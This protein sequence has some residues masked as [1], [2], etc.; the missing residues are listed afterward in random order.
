MAYVE[1]LNY[2]MMD[3]TKKVSDA[4]ALQT[5]ASYVSSTRVIAGIEGT[6][7]GAVA[8]FLVKLN[9][10]DGNYVDINTDTSATAS[11][12]SIGMVTTTSEDEKGFNLDPAAR[13]VPDIAFNTPSGEGKYVNIMPL[14]PGTEVKTA[15]YAVYDETGMASP[16]SGSALSYSVGDY[17]YRSLSGC[18]TNDATN[19]AGYLTT[20]EAD[21]G[22][23]AK[24][25]GQ[26]VEVSASPYDTLTVR[27]I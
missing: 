21:W 12:P 3:S 15:V 2:T 16:G 9:S 19:A 6:E 26:V 4:Y 10:S 1:F 11:S 22:T 8:G 5:Y 18:L 7:V 25:I 24:P 23:V 14:I 13:N 17:V 27:F 20:T